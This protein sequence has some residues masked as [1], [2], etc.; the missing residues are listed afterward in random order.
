MK[1]Q[2][3]FFASCRDVT[4]CRDAEHEVNE[5]ATVGALRQD[6][7]ERFP[8]L[9]GLSA[10]LSVAVNAEYADEATV[11]RPGDQV[12]LIPPVSGG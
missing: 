1:I 9:S 2:L 4:G 11:L 5:G 8:G 6:L 10:A 7:L 12:A 3:L